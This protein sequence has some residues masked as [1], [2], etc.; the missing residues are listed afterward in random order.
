MSLL[1]WMPGQVEQIAAK[2]EKRIRNFWD[3][4]GRPTLYVGFSGG[5]DSAAVLAAAVR[6]VGREAV[7]AWFWHIPGQTHRDNLAAARGVAERLGLGWRFIRVGEPRELQRVDPEPGTVYQ[8]LRAGPPY[9]ALLRLHGPP[10]P[11]PYPR[12]CCKL[13]KEEPLAWLPP[14]KPPYRYIVTGVKR[15]DSR[16]R[17]KRWPQGCEREF[18]APRGIR[19]LAIAPLC[20]L[21]DA[22]VWALLE[23]LGL[24]GIV[25]EQYRKWGRSPNCVL[26]PLASRAQLVRAARLLPHP[27]VQR[28]LDALA[29]WDS[30][31]ARRMREALEQGLV[32]SDGGDPGA[33]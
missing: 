2:V 1:K 13:Y 19:D 20:D 14:Q 33:V 16:A 10:A 32:D 15:A 22:Q 26:C 9:W 30:A 8:V 6:A 24:R 3:R 25:E 12:W 31:L 28:F 27:Y 5:K 4:H 11:P 29:G 17:A 18:R 7:V 23:H 21:D